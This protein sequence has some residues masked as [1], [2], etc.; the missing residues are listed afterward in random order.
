M[1]AGKIFLGGFVF[2]ALLSMVACGGGSN[3]GTVGLNVVPAV[4][5]AD[6]TASPP[7]NS[8]TFTASF[9][10]SAG[11]QGLGTAALVKAN[12]TASDPS[13]QLTV[14]PSP[15]GAASVTATCTATVAGPVT[16]TATSA[17]GQPLM[18]TA[19]LTCN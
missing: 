1:P 4:A 19:N 7:N 16:I 14:A 12:W 17:S 15:T 6:H 11:C 18:G 8:Q 3:C 2:T 13:V 5:S 10:F 9:A